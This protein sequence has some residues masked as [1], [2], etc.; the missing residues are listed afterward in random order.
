MRKVQWRANYAWVDARDKGSD[1]VVGEAPSQQALLALDW[2]PGNV[3]RVSTQLNWFGRIARTE[4][5]TRDAI[6]D[7]TV[8]DLAVRR[9]KLF[10]RAELA[11]RVRNLFDQDYVAPSPGP[12]ATI[13]DDYPQPGVNGDATLRYAF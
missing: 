9:L 7:V 2:Q 1:E 10:G 11:L 6:D 5:D 13:P 3:W 12:G 4:G 8:V